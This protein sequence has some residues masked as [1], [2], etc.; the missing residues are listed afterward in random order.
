MAFDHP[1]D[2]LGQGLACLKA[3]HSLLVQL[4]DRPHPDLHLVDAENLCT[5]V[6]V[7]C[8]IVDDA[9]EGLHRRDAA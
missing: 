2:K 1:L 6:G 4:C 9:Y 3:T 5:L 7:I 8:D